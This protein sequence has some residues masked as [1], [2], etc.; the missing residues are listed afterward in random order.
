M[1]FN[2][3]P[4]IE[5]NFSNMSDVEMQD[6]FRRV[7][8]TENTENDAGNFETYNVR[9]GDKPENVAEEFYG[10]PEYWWVVLLSNGIVDIELEW[11][12]S[13]QEVNFL[14]SNYLN[15]YSYFVMESLDARP[16]DIMVKR[17]VAATGGI[18]I[19]SFG[20]VDK[21]DKLMHRIDVKQFG[22]SIDSGEEFYIYRNNRIED[23]ELEYTLINGFGSTGCYYQVYGATSCISFTGPDADAAPLCATAG[24][25]FAKIQRKEKIK[26]AVEEFTYQSDTISPYG[27]FVEG[28][29]VS[30]NFFS[31][32]NLCGMTGTILYQY[33]TNSISSGV[34]VS[35]VEYNL[36]KLNDE[37]RTIRLLSP[38][39]LS[40]V[41][42][43]LT[44]LLSG[45]VPRGTTKIIE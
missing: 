44:M 23:S 10:A 33:I 2:K 27:R 15:G 25:T 31:F 32:Q 42:I 5:Y 6:I 22:G 1:Y 9:D 37:K 19:E 16:K 34:G 14:F 45:N 13:T 28:E 8:F 36:R 40:K 4:N 11:P 41:S 12:K 29:G 20:V 30:G 39:L 7:K 43:E 3:L 17:D 21:Y 35:T 24:V 18:D 26:D 38:S